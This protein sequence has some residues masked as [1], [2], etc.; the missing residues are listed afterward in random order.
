[1][2]PLRAYIHRFVALPDEAW[3]ALEAELQPRQLKRH[4]YFV[5]PGDTRHEVALLLRGACRMFYPRA[6]GEEVTTYFFFENHLLASYPACLRNAP[7]P[8]A[9]QALEP[10]ELL[11]F[12]YAALTRLYDAW[13][14]FERFG[15][16]LAEYHLIG[17]EERLS[18]LLLYS[19]EARYRALLASSK[20]KIMARI[21]QRLVAAYLGVT[22]VSFSRIRARVARNP[23]PPAG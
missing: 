7:S 23:G 4:E 14:V 6:D 13:P 16:L 5:Q 11:V 12:P 17:T 10:T 19:P 15:R 20:T 9:I 3:R 18:E 22:P 8:L 21:P 1:M 2:H